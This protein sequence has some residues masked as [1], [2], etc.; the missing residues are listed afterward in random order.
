MDYDD[1]AL[2]LAE[3]RRHADAKV[4]G[5]EEKRKQG[6]EFYLLSITLSSKTKQHQVK[7]MCWEL[8]KFVTEG[9]VNLKQERKCNDGLMP[10]MP[11]Y[12]DLPVFKHD[13]FQHNAPIGIMAVDKKIKVDSAIHRLNYHAVAEVLPVQFLRLSFLHSYGGSLTRFVA[14]N[15]EEI[16][17]RTGFMDVHCKRIYYMRGLYDDYI[18][19][20]LI[21]DNFTLDDVIELPLTFRERRQAQRDYKRR[22]K[23]QQENSRWKNKAVGLEYGSYFDLPDE[24][25]EITPSNPGERWLIKRS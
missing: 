4:R 3:I 17:K 9:T 16:K 5:F 22:T 11:S 14:A 19:K 13:G 15:Q 8:Y 21:R 6:S 2:R 1:E 12:P 23:E 25:E 20:H 7:A 10:A 18:V 24:P